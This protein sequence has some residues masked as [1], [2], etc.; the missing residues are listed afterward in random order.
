MTSTI[1]NLAERREQ[2]AAE[3]DVAEILALSVLVAQQ[4]MMVDAESIFGL[5]GD[6]EL[7]ASCV[8]AVLGGQR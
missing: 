2:K 8:P 6:Q 3:R 4:L 5:A 7:I 1:I